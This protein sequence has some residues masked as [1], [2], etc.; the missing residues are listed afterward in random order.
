MKIIWAILIVLV[1]ICIVLHFKRDTPSVY[2]S[3][4]TVRR[5]K[6][7]LD[8]LLSSLPKGFN[9]YIIIYQDEEDGDYYNQTEDGHYEVYL[10][11]NIYE[12]GAWEGLFILKQDGVLQNDDYILMLP[13][14]CKTGGENTIRLV[15]DIISND[16]NFEI[17]WAANTGQCNI[18]IAKSSIIELIR[19]IYKDTHKLDKADSVDMEHGHTHEKSIKKTKDRLKH[20][21]YDEPCENKGSIKVYST[22]VERECIYYKS[23]DVEKYYFIYNHTE[24]YHPETP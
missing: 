21:F 4:V 17:F 20:V 5:Y 14:T 19:E 7:A 22:G 3:I 1:L 18:C 10:K 2:I 6:E 8:N 11:R 23:I 13:D 12:Y 9:K 24:N 16:K 15:K